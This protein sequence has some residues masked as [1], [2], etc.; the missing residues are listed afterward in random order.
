MLKQQEEIKNLKFQH[1]RKTIEMK[2]NVQD[3]ETSKEQAEIELDREAS[4]QLE[5]PGNLLTS[6]D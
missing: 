3:A 5:T 1:A 2:K 6:G 4:A